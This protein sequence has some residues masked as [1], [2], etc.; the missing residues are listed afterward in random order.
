MECSLLRVTRMEG[1]R[2]PTLSLAATITTMP[3]ATSISLN[4]A[5]KATT[6]L[7]ISCLMT[8]ESC[9]T[10]L[11]MAEVEIN[12]TDLVLRIRC[13]AVGDIILCHGCCKGQNHEVKLFIV[14]F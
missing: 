5:V 13:G 10:Q 6:R 3:S 1:S 7:L 11:V 2:T 4:R 8:V 14:S 12:L 9:A